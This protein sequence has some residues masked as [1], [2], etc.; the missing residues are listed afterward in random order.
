MVW[1][2][3]C[4]EYR[5]CVVNELTPP[6]ISDYYADIKCEKG[7]SKVLEAASTVALHCRARCQQGGLGRGNICRS[8][9]ECRVPTRRRT[10]GA[11]LSTKGSGKARRSWE[12]RAGGRWGLEGKGAEVPWRERCQALGVSHQLLLGGVPAACG[13]QSFARCQQQEEEEQQRRPA[14]HRAVAAAWKCARREAGCC[15]GGEPER[16]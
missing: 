8:T 3:P 1:D 7:R 11:R 5:V 9:A 16:S 2:K 13:R 15:S 14:E 4:R 6:F 10:G 12:R